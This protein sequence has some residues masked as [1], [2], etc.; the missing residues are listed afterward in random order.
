[1]ARPI[2]ETPELRGKDAE[3]FEKLIEKAEPVS[4]ARKE[5][6]KKAYEFSNLSVIFNCND[7]LY[8]LMGK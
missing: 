5:A 1:M 6:A 3:R 4:D 7:D 2:K 8:R